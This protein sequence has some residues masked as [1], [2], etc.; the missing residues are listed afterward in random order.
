MRNSGKL[1]IGLVHSIKG[2]SRF[3]LFGPQYF[4]LYNHH[5]RFFYKSTAMTIYLMVTKGTR[6][7]LY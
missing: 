2:V 6:R 7:S 1:F 5:I 4:L 3:K